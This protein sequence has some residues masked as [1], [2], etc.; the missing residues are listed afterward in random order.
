MNPQQL[1]G[2]AAA[3][4]IRRTIDGADGQARLLLDRLLP[5]QVAAITLAVLGD[6]SLALRCRPLIP[7]EIGRHTRLPESILTDERTTFWRNRTDA[8]GRALLLANDDDEQGQSLGD[9]CPI[10][11]AQLLDDPALWIDAADVTLSQDDR[12]AW[13]AALRGLISARSISLNR[14]AEYVSAT[15]GHLI[16]DVLPLEEALGRALPRLQIPRDT[17]FFAGFAQA[18]RGNA[19]KWRQ[20]YQQAWRKRA[21]YLSKRHPGDQPIDLA[22]LRANLEKSRPQLA[23][24]VF[25]TLCAFV[26]APPTWCDAVQ[27]AAEL[28]WERDNVRVLFEGLRKKKE[29][30]GAATVTHFDEKLP[31]ALSGDERAYLE[32]FDGRGSRE[33]DDD[34]VEFYERHRDHLALSPRLKVSWDRFVFGRAIETDDLRVGLLLAI[35]DLFDQIG[36][37]PH[38]RTLTIECLRH[39]VAQWQDVNKYAARYFSRRYRGLPALFGSNVEWKPASLFDDA[40]QEVEAKKRGDRVSTAKAANQVK[41]TVRLSPRGGDEEDAA[42]K[43]VIWH[44][45]PRAIAVAF[46]SDWEYIAGHPFAAISVTRETVSTKGRLQSLDLRD[47]QTFMPH[48]SQQRGSLVAQRDREPV[49][50]RVRRGLTSALREAWIDQAGVRPDRRAVGGLRR[51]ISVRH[52]GRAGPGHRLARRAGSRGDVRR[53]ARRPLRAR[54][55]RQGARGPVAPGGRARSGERAGG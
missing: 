41:F 53:P 30:V 38:G 51:A 13:I 55:E 22:E 21:P 28:E 35:R 47:V 6:A 24:G 16:D 29:K 31:N 23:D 10:G 2:A 20:A 42:S 27:R 4:L 15:R 32:R 17:A 54:G 43:Q 50:A 45:D 8:D 49:D 44:F 34:D 25:A 40:V 26:E 14:F 7:R 39:N 19:A 5:E 48:G 18:A 12:R 46:A 3:T 36:E 33:P 9:L 11:S 37:A 52:S 1:L